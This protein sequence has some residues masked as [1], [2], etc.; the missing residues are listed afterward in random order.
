MRL[1]ST[2]VFRLMARHVLYTTGK[3]LVIIDI[4]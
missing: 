4:A 1:C 3:H 2:R